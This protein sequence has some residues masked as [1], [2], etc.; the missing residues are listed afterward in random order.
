[1]WRRKSGIKRRKALRA[2][3]SS[4]PP[5]GW[6]REENTR[7][8]GLFLQETAAAAPYS[9]SPGGLGGG[10]RRELGAADAAVAVAIDRQPVGAERL[11]AGQLGAGE[12]TVVVF[13]Q[14][15]EQGLARR[16]VPAEARTRGGRAAR[17]ALF[18]GRN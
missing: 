17:S 18:L 4:S 7:P 14:A 13:V 1:G 3:T 9:L 10:D 2:R 11:H 8:K 15:V 5:V 16:G 12:V 6:G